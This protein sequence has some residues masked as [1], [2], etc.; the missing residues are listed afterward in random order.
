MTVPAS[1]AAIEA[2]AT[3]AGLNPG[4]MALAPEATLAS[5]E[6]ANRPDLGSLP[7]QVAS[8]STAPVVTEFYPD[9]SLLSRNQ[10]AAAPAQAPQR[11]G[12]LGNLFNSSK[13]RR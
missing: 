11:R 6:G 13:R 1:S 10:P 4:T 5:T 9:P 12:V 3:P 8:G 7:G 2:T